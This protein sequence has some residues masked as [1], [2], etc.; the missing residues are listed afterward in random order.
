MTELDSF[1]RQVLPCHKRWSGSLAAW[2]S[3]ETAGQGSDQARARIVAMES[4]TQPGST[5][6]ILG[7]RGVR[8][9]PARLPSRVPGKQTPLGD[10]E[11]ICKKLRV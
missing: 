2:G 7:H 1:S 4:A 8:E 11:G 5:F 10:L 9:T 3:F 6:R